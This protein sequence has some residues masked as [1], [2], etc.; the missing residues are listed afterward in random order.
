MPLTWNFTYKWATPL[1]FLKVAQMKNSYLQNMSIKKSFPGS[2]IFNLQNVE[3]YLVL[4]DSPKSLVSNGF[5]FWFTNCTNHLQSHIRS[6][7][8]PFLGSCMP[9]RFTISLVTR[10]GNCFLWLCYQLAMYDD[11]SLKEDVPSYVWNVTV[12]SIM[13]KGH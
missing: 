9:C 7:H 8:Y 6:S 3:Q 13:V 5:F 1:L 2:F 12:W 4:K 10:N 11:F